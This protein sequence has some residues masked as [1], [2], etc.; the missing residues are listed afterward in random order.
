[1][2][3]EEDITEDI[4]AAIN[5]RDSYRKALEEIASNESGVNAERADGIA[6][7]APS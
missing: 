5:E 6:I 3:S 7:A 1:M 4:L 2:K